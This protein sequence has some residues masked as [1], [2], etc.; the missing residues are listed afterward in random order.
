MASGGTK[1]G[2]GAGRRRQTERHL[3]ASQQS[4]V[5]LENNLRRG[6]VE[7]KLPEHVEGT[8][9]NAEEQYRL[10]VKL[11]TT[12]GPRDVPVGPIEVQV[13]K[14][15]KR[16]G[17]FR[18]V[19]VLPLTAEEVAAEELARANA[20]DP[21]LQ[22]L[23]QNDELLELFRAM[24][25]QRDLD[26]TQLT[27]LL[28]TL[29]KAPSQKVA[30][31]R[32]VECHENLFL[33]GGAGKGKTHLLRCIISGLRA[34]G[35][36]VA[37]L[38]PTGVAAHHIQGATIHSFM[39]LA[40]VWYTRPLSSVMHHFKKKPEKLLRFQN[41]PTIVVDEVSMVPAKM[42]TWLDHIL[43]L[44][45]R[46]TK[47]FGGIQMI[48]CGDFFQLPPVASMNVCV[49][50]TTTT[51]TTESAT[52]TAAAAVDELAEKTVEAKRLVARTIKSAEQDAFD[53][54]AKTLRGYPVT[55]QVHS[56]RIAF[57][58]K[59]LE[60]G[61]LQQVDA[62][63]VAEQLVK[64]QRE[65]PAFCFETPIWQTT[66]GPDH[67]IELQESFR[68]VD[69]VFIALLNH[70]RAG[71][72][73]D[74]D[75]DLLHMRHQNTLKRM[76]AESRQQRWRRMSAAINFQELNRFRV[77]LFSTCAQVDGHNAD[78]HKRL[79]RHDNPIHTYHTTY[80][81]RPW[82]DKQIKRIE[83]Q[84]VWFANNRTK[85]RNDQRLFYAEFLAE[86]EL[87]REDALE[88]LDDEVN[89]DDKVEFCVGARV[90]LMKNW[91]T[92]KG[93]VHGRTG[94]IVGFGR[95]GP[96]VVFDEKDVDW[97]TADAVDRY[98]ASAVEVPPIEW[99]TI[100]NEGR[101][102]AA[103][104]P[105]GYA[106]AITIHKAQGLSMPRADMDLAYLFEAGQGYV[107]LSR[108]TTLQEL[109]LLNLE[110]KGIYA[111]PRVLKFYDHCFPP[112]RPTPHPSFLK[113]QPLKLPP[114]SFNRCTT[115]TTTTT[116]T[117]SIRVEQPPDEKDHIATPIHVSTPKTPATPIP[118]PAPALPL[119]P[120][121][122]TTSVRFGFGFANGAERERTDRLLAERFGDD[123]VTF[124]KLHMAGAHA[125]ASIQARQDDS[126]DLT[127]PPEPAPA[128]ARSAKKHKFPPSNNEEEDEEE[129]EK[130]HD[131][132]KRSRI[133]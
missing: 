36:Q 113:I 132:F 73:T 9:W 79:Q 78:M 101:V 45:N 19:L 114:L 29:E 28:K 92:G 119:P 32:A 64:M 129:E 105:L 124:I 91:Q 72:L 37:V 26:E 115:T 23:L 12:L 49:K 53:E 111:D 47:P 93:L 104:I 76:D 125:R 131:P 18:Q 100:C 22:E 21:I 120:H 95:D 94:W 46:N 27:E 3:T 102:V 68:Q 7:R 25:A 87:S 85:L 16:G 55:W 71:S 63:A 86:Y 59:Q 67:C 1:R 82:T 77:R 103:Q 31:H 89:V 57:A 33:T 20:Q 96:L 122:P 130:K 110:P 56:N 75:I 83:D 80:V 66:F 10:E 17:G 97:S 128:P 90:M 99:S 81:L 62:A 108:L 24:G 107:A 69:P 116:T 61:E 84:K 88:K 38:A 6:L 44:A 127:A 8:P 2:G 133:F 54:K 40:P 14:H 11:A 98:L 4:Q 106:W 74:A 123:F 60:D 13:P 30:Y 51:T 34:S 121:P 50:P 65:R 126:L 35:R 43:K 5:N 112:D 118:E 42:F 117:L 58:R 15:A 52:G 39:K 109:G 41:F 70:A 48:V